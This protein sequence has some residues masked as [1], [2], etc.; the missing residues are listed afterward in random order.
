MVNGESEEYLHHLQVRVLSG[1]LNP[2]GETPISE[3]TAFHKHVTPE[4]FVDPVFSELCRAAKDLFNR[5]GDC[6]PVI[7]LSEISTKQAQFHYAD[8]HHGISILFEATDANNV[9][10]VTLS[11]YLPILN[12]VALSKYLPAAQ[13]ELKKAVD[14]GMTYEEAHEKFVAPVVERYKYKAY[15]RFDVDKQVSEL[16][17]KVAGFKDAKVV[18]ENVIP[19]GYLR[20][21]RSLRGGMRP[22]QLIIVG[23]RPATGKTTMALNIVAN[24]I[25]NNPGKHAVFVSLEQTSDQLVEKIVSLK[26]GCQFPKTESELDHVRLIGGIERIEKATQEF[27]FDRLHVVEKTE[28]I[29]ALGQTIMELCQKHDVGVVVI[30]YLQL[31]PFSGERSRYEAITKISNKLK[32]LAKDARIPIVCLAQLS[33]GNDSE[34]RTPRLSDLRD[35]GSIEQ[36]ADIAAL[37]YNEP[38]ESEEESQISNY[39]TVNFDIQKNRNGALSTIKMEFLPAESKFKELPRF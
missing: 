15:E 23:A 37:L 28:N 26:A 34:G 33:R 14:A 29:D 24:V 1:L 10:S 32:V 8:T 12:R 25:D 36:D 22:S 13:K 39:R 35:S 6:D 9:N 30:D 38:N 5:T 27:S 3:L 4:T 16:K 20:I 31:I 19:T 11:R 17:Q 2:G 7:L 18:L 21:D